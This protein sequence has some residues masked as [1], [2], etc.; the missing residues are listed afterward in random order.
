MHSI[1]SAPA[2]TS[3]SVAFSIMIY[4]NIAQTSAVNLEHRYLIV[5]YSL[6]QSSSR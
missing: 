5:C 2:V 3:F 1:L 4:L 6:I